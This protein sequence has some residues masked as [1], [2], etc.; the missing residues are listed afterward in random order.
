[1]D[2]ILLADWHLIFFEIQVGATLLKDTNDEILGEL[3]LVGETSTRD[4][5]KPGTGQSLGNLLRNP[6]YVRNAASRSEQSRVPESVV[7]GTR[8][9]LPPAQARARPRSA[10]LGRERNVAVVQHVSTDV[11]QLRLVADLKVV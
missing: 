10:S 5:F 6:M 3:V 11:P 8:F 2:G 1:M 4:R 9:S 7:P